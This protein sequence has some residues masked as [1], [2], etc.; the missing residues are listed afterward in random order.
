MVIV[1]QFL[2]FVKEFGHQF[3]IMD[4]GA[5]VAEGATTEVTET[6]IAEHLHV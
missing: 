4:R 3:Y 6:L 1:E 2:D 5:V